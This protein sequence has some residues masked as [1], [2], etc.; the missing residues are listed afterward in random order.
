MDLPLGCVYVCPAF[1]LFSPQ[2]PA[3]AFTSHSSREVGQRGRG[4]GTGMRYS[5][6]YGLPYG[7]LLTSVSNTLVI[8][9][10]FPAS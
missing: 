4:L 2:E 9:K 10:L 7:S 5:P 8:Y 3:G 1:T 6:S